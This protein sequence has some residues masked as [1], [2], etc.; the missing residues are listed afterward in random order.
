L[1]WEPWKMLSNGY[2]V[3]LNNAYRFAYM[4]WITTMN[5]ID[6]ANMNWVL[7][8][9][10][11]A[12]MLSNYAVNILWKVPDTSK[13]IIFWDVS[14]SL[15]AQYGNWVTLAYQL[16]IMWQ[17]IKDFRPYDLVT[18]AEFATALSRLLYWLQDWQINYYS[19][20]INKLHD[21]WIISNTNPNMH[22]LRGYVMLMLMRSAMKN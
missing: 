2:S 9:I 6:N 11:M 16:W 8:R 5:N 1:V 19:T 18:R 13:N 20:H 10:E 3:E 7:R 12:K 21:N 4:N 22:E 17:N 14:N 15:N